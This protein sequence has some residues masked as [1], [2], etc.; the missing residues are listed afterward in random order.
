MTTYVNTPSSE[1]FGGFKGPKTHHFSLSLHS[2]S[3]GR[4]S[5]RDSLPLDLRP[6]GPFRG[7]LGPFRGVL[8][9]FKV[10]IRSAVVAIFKPL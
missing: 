7:A 4:E 5:L 8:G 2:Q 3:R 6:V 1:I 9:Q 10:V